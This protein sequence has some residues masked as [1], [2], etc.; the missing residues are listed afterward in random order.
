MTATINTT[1]DTTELQHVAPGELTIAENVRTSTLNITETWID[2]LRENGVLVPVRATRDPDGTLRVEDGQRRTLGAIAAE[3][4]TIPVY[5]I[6]DTLGGDEGTID[7]ITGQLVTND[8]RTGLNQAERVEA[9]NQLALI[10]VSAAQIAKRTGTDR[11]T[12][13]RSLKIGTS[14]AARAALQTPGD[15]TLDHLAMLADFDGDE[16]AQ[17]RI[18][19]AFSG[20]RVHVHARLIQERADRAAY[21]QHATEYAQQY[22][23]E[24]GTA[25]LS[26]LPFNANGHYGATTETPDGETV[27]KLGY[28]YTENGTGEAAELSNVTDP[29][30]LWVS[31]SSET[32]YRTA[33]GETV[34]PWQVEDWQDPTE[35]DGIDPDTDEP[36]EVDPDLIDPATVAE[37]TEWTATWWVADPAADSLARRS[38]NGQPIIPTGQDDATSAEEE[39]EAKK[40]ARRQL[41]AFNKAADAAQTVRREHLTKLLTRKTPP[42][43]AAELTARVMIA[44]GAGHRQVSDPDVKSLAAKLLGETSYGSSWATKP[45]TPGRAQVIALAYALAA[46]ETG[47]DRDSHRQESR[48]PALRDYLAFL[49][50]TGYTVAEVETIIT[51]QADRAA[52]LAALKGEPLADDSDDEDHTDECD[53]PDADDEEE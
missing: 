3:L 51:D 47:Y 40:V 37:T 11:A 42:K 34:E 25:Y 26:V 7:R 10:G 30:R 21:D 46:H 29:A 50:T 4:P 36:W 41:I 8:Q 31:F 44:G 22:A 45:M 17:A 49:V 20:N 9:V 32:T 16:Q 6:G 28:L 19:Q 48:H 39:A 2:N 33:D 43:G 35:N 52:V 1:V 15:L 23:A 38:Y 14:Q 27:Y 13:D 24:H 53:V 18:I 12:V 5:V